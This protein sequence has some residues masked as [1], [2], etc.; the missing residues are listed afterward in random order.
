MHVRMN[1][2]ISG[3]GEPPASYTPARARF[4]KIRR[5]TASCRLA[6]RPL[7]G[8][9]FGPLT[10]HAPAERTTKVRALHAVGRRGWC[11]ASLEP[12]GAHPGGATYCPHGPR[13]S[14]CP[15]F[16]ACAWSIARFRRAS[17]CRIES[18]A[19]VPAKAARYD[20][21][22]RRRTRV[23]GAASDSAAPATPTKRGGTTAGLLDWS[24]SPTN[25]AEA[26]CAHRHQLSCEI[27]ADRPWSKPARRRRTGGALASAG[28]P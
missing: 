2:S 6:L 11:R 20:D 13:G 23:T 8:S 17:T 4:P 7:T 3:G 15:G 19:S 25:S 26:T 14:S 10:P 1:A 12:A 27:L 21:H 16:R 22:R 5:W 28:R 24:A 18:S 9:R